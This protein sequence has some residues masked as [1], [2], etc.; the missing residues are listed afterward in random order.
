MQIHPEIDNTRVAFC[1]DPSMISG[2]PVDWSTIEAQNEMVVPDRVH[3][4][5][6][7]M[8]M[9]I[10]EKATPEDAWAAIF[11]KPESKEWNEVKVAVK[12]NSVEERHLNR[13]AVI[14]KVCLAIID[15]GVL[16]EN[17]TI[18]DAS[19]GISGTE[20]YMNLY[21]TDY[22][23][24][25][26]PP[27]VQ[28]STTLGG[29]RVPITLPDS[30]EEPCTPQLA[31]GTI[32]ILINIAVNKGH[33]I[34]YSGRFTLTLKNHLGSLVFLHP[35]AQN[36]GDL[37]QITPKL[38]AMNQSTAILG[39]GDPPR[40]QLCIVDSLWASTGGP[41]DTPNRAPCCLVMGTFSPIVDYLTVRRIREE[42][43]ENQGGTPYGMGMTDTDEEVL[44]R[45]LSDFGYDMEAEEIRDLD[46]IDA[47]TYEPPAGTKQINPSDDE[48]QRNITV[49]APLFKP[50]RTVFSLS[51]LRDNPEIKIYSAG[52]RLVRSFMIAS[53]K[54]KEMTIQWDGRDRHAIMVPAG[55]YI[56]KL[57]AGNQLMSRKLVLLK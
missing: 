51:G 52:G 10:A 30:S 8:A 40:Q 41:H 31:D 6:D 57:R 54:N 48:V 35:G 17:I 15:L 24:Q 28:I 47:L 5:M 25:R 4:N 36:G 22:A 49:S 38:I 39:E 1:H 56:I 42:R 32:D 14:E 19:W 3:E 50:A 26:L 33:G 29:E 12:I 27:G 53:N 43:P 16:N 9:A 46:F 13:L 21:E 7:K 37:P 34:S 23:M 2:N 55:N 44:G 20:N 11:R 45:F 18:Y